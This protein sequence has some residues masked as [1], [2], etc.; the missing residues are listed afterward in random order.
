MA[1]EIIRFPVL[2]VVPVIKLAF[3]RI[4]FALV[5]M[6]PLSVR[7]TDAAVSVPDVWV[8]EPEDLSEMP[9][10]V[11]VMSPATATETEEVRLKVPA[12]PALDASNVRGEEL[13][14]VIVTLPLL[15]L[16]ESVEADESTLMPFAAVS[17]A[18]LVP[19]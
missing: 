7:L 6:L 9:P 2:L 3:V 19:I 17:T 15:E 8:I 18:D 16:A 5:P 14:C 11:A 1:S 10:P 13:I 12:F 4:G